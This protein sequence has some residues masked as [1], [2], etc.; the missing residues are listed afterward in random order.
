MANTLAILQANCRQEFGRVADPV[1]KEGLRRHEIQILHL[2]ELHHFL[3]RGAGRG[4]IEAADYFQ[5]LCDVLSRSILAPLALRCEAF[6]GEGVLD[7]STCEWLGLIISE[8]VMNAAKHAFPDRTEGRVRI[9]IYAPDGMAWCC[10]VADNGCGIGK[11][12]AGGTGSRIV[13]TLVQ[14]LDGQL[15]VDSGPSGTTIVLRFPAPL[16]KSAPLTSRDDR[17]SVTG[18]KV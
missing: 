7:A 3:S 15:A 2:A 18:R 17:A 10:T 1:L 14:M 5:P 11:T 12:A 9:E 8:L 13:D 16:P 6:V 4:E